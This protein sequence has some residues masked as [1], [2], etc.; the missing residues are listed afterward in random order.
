MEKLNACRINVMVSDMGQ[1]VKFYAETLGLELKNHYGNHY[2]EIQAANL[3][4]GLHPRTEKTTLGNNL[5][6]GFGVFEFD[7]NVARLREKGIEIEIEQ[8]GWIR[9]AYFADPDGNSLYLAE[10]K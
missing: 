8:D 9:L 10:N 1:A 6:I 2:A 5:S 3:L 7:E 4:L